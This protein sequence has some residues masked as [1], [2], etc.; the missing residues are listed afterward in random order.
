MDIKKENNYEN[1]I[2]VGLLNVLNVMKMY[3]KEIE[4][5]KMLLVGEEV[6]LVKEIINLFLVVKEKFIN[7]NYR[8]V[9]SIVKRYKRDSIDML[10]LI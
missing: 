8:L 1:Y 5:Y 4:E 2:C 3:L 6:E 7:L 9:V 10:D